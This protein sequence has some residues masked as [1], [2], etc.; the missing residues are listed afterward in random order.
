[1]T[2]LLGVARAD[3]DMTVLILDN[4][5]VAMTGA[6]DSMTTGERLLEVLQGL[7]VRDEHLRVI[8]PH[9]KHHAENVAL[10]RREIEHHGLS[11]IV[12]ARECIHLKR[13]LEARSRAAVQGPVPV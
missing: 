4:A 12:A 11:V 8:E 5:T 6:Q 1:M 9:P 2:A 3:A 10:I 13:T 7:G